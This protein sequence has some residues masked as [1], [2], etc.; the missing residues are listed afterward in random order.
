[1]SYF[2]TLPWSTTFNYAPQF[3]DE[4]DSM[5]SDHS[6]KQCAIGPV[7]GQFARISQRFPKVRSY[8]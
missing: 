5:K 4:L 1:M 6:V 3:Y 2:Y 8:L 7:I